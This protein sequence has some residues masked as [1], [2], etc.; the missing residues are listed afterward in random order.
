MSPIP[1][2][3][4]SPHDPA[5]DVAPAPPAEGDTPPPL[6]DV[7]TLLPSDG[8]VLPRPEQGLAEQARRAEVFDALFGKPVLRRF[9]RYVVLDV[10]GKG[11]MGLV[12]K[13]YD[14]QLDR[15]VAIKVLH[16]HLGRQHTAR[17]ERE[18]QAMARLSH[19]HVV[20]VYEV[21]ELEGRTFV[22]MELVKGQTVRQW[23]DQQPR[24]GWAACVE[25]FVQLGEGLAAAHRRGL[26]HRDFKPGNAMLDEDGRARVLDFGLARR[27]GEQVDDAPNVIQRARTDVQQVVP[28]EQPLTQTGAVLGTPAYM[29]PEQMGGQEADARSDQ[30]SFCVTLYE[31]LYGERPYEGETMSALMVAMRGGQ[32]RPAPRGSDV[33]TAL[34]RVLLRGLAAEP[35]ERWPSMEALLEELRR[36]V[37]PSRGWRWIAG[38]GAVALLAGL[39]AVWQRD[40]ISEQEGELTE[41]EAQLQEKVDELARE[42]GENRRLT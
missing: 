29:P 25:L 33:P 12:L 21:G 36:L 14:E 1:E 35:A 34:R 19:P 40:V 27:G 15:P 5:E 6:A 32:V 23:M 4:R 28:L 9:G 8:F 22:A 41:K 13:G 38:V 18:A 37:A 42:L 10:L 39:V 31:A 7:S 24:P 30:F 26:V 16:E 2:S 17:L 3:E 11:G 20:Q